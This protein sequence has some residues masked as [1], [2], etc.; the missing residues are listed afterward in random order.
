MPGPA[1]QNHTASCDCAYEKREKTQIH[2]FLSSIIFYISY[3]S[4]YVII[5]ISS[6]L[7]WVIFSYK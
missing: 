2:Y 4:M 1:S 6:S 5:I 7:S 3:V